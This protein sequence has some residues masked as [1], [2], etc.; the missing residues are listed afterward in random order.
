MSLT[1]LNWKAI[2]LAAGCPGLK[3]ALMSELRFGRSSMPPIGSFGISSD[4]RFGRDCARQNGLRRPYKIHGVMFLVSALP[5]RGPT[6]MSY[7]DLGPYSRKVTTSSPEAQLWFDRGLNWLF[8]F[9]HGEAIKCFR[10]ALEHDGECAMAHWGV[11]YASGPN[12]NVPWKRY[13]PQGRQQ[14]LSASYDAMKDA[15]AHAAKASPVERA[16][17]AALPA[18]YPQR[19]AIEDMMPW[20][21]AYAAEMRQSVFGCI[22]A[23]SRGAQRARR[24]DHG[25][26][27]V[28][29][30]GS[31]QRASP[32]EG[33]ATAGMQ[34]R[35]RTGVR[36]YAR[37]L[38]SPR[39]AASLCPP[40]GDVAVPGSCAAR[41]RPPAHDHAGLRPSHPYADASRRAVRALQRRAATIRRRW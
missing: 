14:A 32:P 10:K 17:I 11:S 30:V 29:D 24:G 35:P 38:G 40:D 15:L 8:G 22:P 1:P 31:A 27:A 4:A 34:G 3:S 9:N 6:T 19:E 37:G 16:M 39:P 13:D 33:A 20:D 28:E 36:G 5:S 12:Y 41:R 21:K 18:R 25:R 23:R 7:F 26:D 2:I